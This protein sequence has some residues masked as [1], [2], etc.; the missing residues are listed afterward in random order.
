MFHYLSWTILDAIKVNETAP[1]FARIHFY[2]QY[3]LMYVEIHCVLSPG[4]YVEWTAGHPLDAHRRC[5]YITH[6]RPLK[7]ASQSS[8]SAVTL[9]ASVNGYRKGICM[10]RT[11]GAG[12][13]LGQDR[14]TVTIWHLPLALSPLPFYS[15]SFL[16]RSISLSPCQE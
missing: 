10:Q 11:Y 6:K 5:T 16:A 13:S 8:V 3:T 7:L 4:M 14:S 9:M 15:S 2:R 12:R 1:I